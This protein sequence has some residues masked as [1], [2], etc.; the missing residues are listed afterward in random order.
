MHACQPHN[1]CCR[2]QLQQTVKGWLLGNWREFIHMW[3]SIWIK[4]AFPLPIHGVTPYI[5][6]FIRILPYCLVCY[7]WIV[8]N[9]M[10]LNRPLLFSL[11]FWIYTHQRMNHF[12]FVF[13]LQWNK[14]T[15]KL[16]LTVLFAKTIAWKAAFN[17]NPNPGKNPHQ[18]VIC[19]AK[20][21][22]ITIL[23]PIFISWT[24]SSP[25]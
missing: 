6:S 8:Q 21:L 4:N 11:S 23:L 7:Q 24:L 14:I 9:L 10:G 18:F 19:N 3:C 22:D 17:C 25:D 15:R 12:S 16:I 2:K 1:N 13:G 20:V 5:S